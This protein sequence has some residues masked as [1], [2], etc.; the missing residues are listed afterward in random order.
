MQERRR[1]HA[2]LGDYREASISSV[3][4]Y[5]HSRIVGQHGPITSDSAEEVS[6]R[7]KRV[8]NR[9]LTKLVD[10]VVKCDASDDPPSANAL[11]DE[12]MM[13]LKEVRMEWCSQA[14][15][16]LGDEDD[17]VWFDRWLGRTRETG[18]E[19]ALRGRWSGLY[20][21]LF[22]QDMPI[23]AAL[24]ARLGL[25]DGLIQPTSRRRRGESARGSGRHWIE[26][27]E[28]KAAIPEGRWDERHFR[29]HT[30]VL[31]ET[32]SGKTK[33]AILPVLAAAYRSPRVGIGLV[34]DPKRELGNVLDMWDRR[35]RGGG[36]SKKLKWIGSG[37]DIVNLMASDEWS[38]RGMIERQEYRSAAQRILG[39]IAGLTES[40]PARVLL[41]A[42][43]TDRNSYWPQEGTEFASTVLGLAIELMTHPEIYV[44]PETQGMTA[45]E[46]NRMLAVATARLNAI[47]V[48]LGVFEDVREGYVREAEEGREA[49]GRAESGFPHE[50]DVDRYRYDFDEDY[51]D[52]E[53]EGPDPGKLRRDSAIRNLGSKLKTARVFPKEDKLIE[54]MLERWSE[55]EM[56]IDDFDAALR[57]VRTS[58]LMKSRDARVANVLV[59]AS[60][61]C[62]ELFSMN[63]SEKVRH[64]NGSEDKGQKY[65]PLEALADFMVARDGGAPGEIDLIGKRMKEYAQMREESPP[66]YA[67]V[68]GTATT[69]WREF[70]SGEIRYSLYFGCEMH[71]RGRVSGREPDFL[72]FRKQVGRDQEDIEREPGSFYVYQPALNRSGILF[73]RVCK[74]LFFESILGDE[75]R[76]ANGEEMPS[77]AYIADEFQRFITVER[78]HGEQSFLDVCRSFGAFTVIA[79]Q[80]VANLYY[81]LCEFEKDEGKRRSAIDIICNNTATKLFFRNSDKDTSDRLHT[82]CPAMPGGNVVA[83]VR[84]LSTLGVGECYAS[85]PDGRFVRVQLDE[86][87]G[88]G[89]PDR[90]VD[91]SDDVVPA[92]A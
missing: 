25:I 63:E 20:D 54:S 27:P 80:S 64:G 52:L 28:W 34:I 24:A 77:A 89:E 8:D 38:V 31:G 15:E 73:A 29:R 72:D 68:Y 79:C 23:S 84:P 60:A 10:Q 7:L 43:P 33:S 3:L 75:A 66:Q 41:G 57:E 91:G 85:F 81:A 40:N 61:I 88:S 5:H 76:A 86:F 9:M 18:D 46:G 26:V 71:G 48:R 62:S 36:A 14:N 74:A 32:G 30:L 58:I 65:T 50:H 51:P 6:E 1:H 69:V 92:G 4:H 67:G 90:R 2:S 49:A 37:R 87:D 59:V 82:I 11:G 70:I 13:A 55:S 16:R 21:A 78:E 19:Q 45:G 47:G 22:E 83:R 17:L 56:S 39:R 35:D 42:P 12:D 44:G 53:D